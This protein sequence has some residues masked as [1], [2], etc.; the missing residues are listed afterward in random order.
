MSEIH[1]QEVQTILIRHDRYTMRQVGAQFS[2]II[3][4]VVVIQKEHTDVPNITHSKTK[5]H[6][7]SFELQ[8]T[9]TK[10]S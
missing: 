3:T 6:P 1:L 7:K 5:K 10:N 9:F 8:T 4:K 2:T